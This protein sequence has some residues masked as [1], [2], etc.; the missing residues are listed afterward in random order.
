[1][2][3]PYLSVY[4]VFLISTN[5]PFCWGKVCR[6][7]AKKGL[8][9]RCGKPCQA[10]AREGWQNV[11]QVLPKLGREGKRTNIPVTGIWGWLTKK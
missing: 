7:A 1:M 11:A 10:T 3:F 4:L 6:L 5:K 2:S 8:R 9:P